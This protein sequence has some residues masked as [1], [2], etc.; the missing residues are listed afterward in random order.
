VTRSGG[1]DFGAR[2][3]GEEYDRAI[4][5]LHSGLPPVPSRQQRQEIRRRELDLVIDYRLG[6]EFP[7]ARRDALWVVQQRVERRRLSLMFKYLFRR[8][9]AKSLIKGAQGL[10]GDVVEAYRSV[11][12]EAELEQFFGR[13]ETRRPALPV[14]LEQLGK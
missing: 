2:L 4:V 9:F 1:L 8:L 6:R 5:A 13:E 3:T 12:D 11:L 7:K 14:D 10:A